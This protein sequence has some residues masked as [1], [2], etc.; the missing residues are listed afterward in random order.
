MKVWRDT[1]LAECGRR[2]GPPLR[3]DEEAGGGGRRAQEFPPSC[4]QQSFLWLRE[5]GGWGCMVM[6]GVSGWVGGR[7][8]DVHW[9]QS[10][11]RAKNRL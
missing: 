3:G 9:D 10:R 6:D 1:Q 11:S 4:Q 2:A 5:A 7:W 8:L